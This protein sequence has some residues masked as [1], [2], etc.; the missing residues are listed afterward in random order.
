M[1]SSKFKRLNTTWK[2]KKGRRPH[3]RI[4][5]GFV[6]H[7]L[8][9]GLMTSMQTAPKKFTAEIRGCARCWQHQRCCHSPISG[10]IPSFTA[11]DGKFGAQQRDQRRQICREHPGGQDTATSN[12]IPLCTKVLKQLK[13]TPQGFP[14]IP[15]SMDSVV[16]KC[17]KG[18]KPPPSSTKL[19]GSEP[20]GQE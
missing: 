9:G 16:C 20:L 6:S 2:R 10:G 8:P 13:N 19:W 4:H 18:L 7:S 11:G 15:I 14:L 12:Y 1:Y 5:R 3:Q 17:A